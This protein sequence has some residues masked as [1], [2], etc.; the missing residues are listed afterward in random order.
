MTPQE[1]GRQLRVDR[2]VTG[3]FSMHQSELRVTVEAVDV[4]GDRLLWRDTIAAPAMT[5]L[6]SA[7]G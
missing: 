4:D 5:R 2:I 3:H 7:I 1:A 6:R